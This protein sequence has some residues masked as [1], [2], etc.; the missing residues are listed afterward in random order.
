MTQEAFSE[1]LGVGEKY[2]SAIECGRRNLSEKMLYKILEIAPVGTRREWLSGEDDFETERDLAEHQWSQTFSELE[3]EGKTKEEII[4]LAALR[5]G[6]SLSR[7]DVSG[8]NKAINYVFLNER[9]EEISIPLFGDSGIEDILD[10]VLDF[11][12]LRLKW[13]IDRKKRPNIP[14]TLEEGGG[15]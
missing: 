7:H 6:Y 2:I 15:K 13:S 1:R 10:N 8:A 14:W 3:S 11:A 5:N 4:R 12:A 9:G